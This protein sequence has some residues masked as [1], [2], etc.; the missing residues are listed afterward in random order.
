MYIMLGLV[1]LMMGI[2]YF[3]FMLNK[4]LLEVLIVI[5]VVFVIVILGGFDVVMVGSFICDGGGEG[6]KGGLL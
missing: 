6:L 3:L 5:G 1:V 2:M 4:K